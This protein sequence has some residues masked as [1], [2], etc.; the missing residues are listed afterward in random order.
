M[1][2]NAGRTEIDETSKWTR[3][4]G[5]KRGGRSRG[6]RAASGKDLGTRVE[7]DELLALELGML[8]EHL[9]EADEGLGRLV[10]VGLVDLVRHQEEVLTAAEAQHGHHVVDR[11]ALAGGVAGVDDD[12]RAHV[13]AIDTCLRDGSLEGGDLGSVEE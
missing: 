7:R 11:E 3:N 2:G 8:K 6:S 5:M 9:A 4:E 1:P 10:D 12:H 13:D